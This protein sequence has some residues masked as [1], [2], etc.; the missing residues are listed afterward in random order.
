MPKRP[1]P[2]AQSAGVAH[3]RRGQ[4]GFDKASAVLEQL[5]EQRL[6]VGVVGAE[7]GG[8]LAVLLDPLGNMLKDV[9]LGAGN[10][11]VS[12]GVGSG[13]KD[14][15]HAELFAGSLHDRHAA[16]HGLVGHMA[17]EGD[18]DE[19]VAAHLVSGA[20]HQVAAGD[21]VVVDDQVGSGA[22]LGQVFV[23]LTSDAEDVGAAL[24]DLTE[25]LSR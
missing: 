12:G 24:F 17:R 25:S 13:L 10:T 18:V 9:G 3:Q 23:G 2:H 7:V 16:A 22:D 20:D 1:A 11:D 14:E 15:L 21:E 19:G 4:V 6:G 8:M 5:L